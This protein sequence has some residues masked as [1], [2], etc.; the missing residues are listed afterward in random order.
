[1]FQV[2]DRVRKRSYFG[3]SAP[4][5]RDPNLNGTVIEINGRWITVRHDEGSSWGGAVGA[6]PSRF[7]YLAEDLEHLNPVLR[8]V[9]EL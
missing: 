1:M 6:V 3:D 8:L 4:K 7:D 5:I 2:N 9:A